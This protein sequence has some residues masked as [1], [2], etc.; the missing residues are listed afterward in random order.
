MFKSNDLFG[1]YR[2]APVYSSQSPNAKSTVT[3]PPAARQLVAM[4]RVDV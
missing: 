2:E 4:R 1:R 3:N